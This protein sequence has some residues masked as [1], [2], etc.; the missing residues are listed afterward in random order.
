MHDNNTYHRSLCALTFF[1]RVEAKASVQLLMALLLH[2]RLAKYGI[3]V[4]DV[5]RLFLLLPLLRHVDS[6]AIVRS[7]KLRIHDNDR[8]FRENLNGAFIIFANDATAKNITSGNCILVNV[9]VYA[10][11]FLQMLQFLYGLAIAGDRMS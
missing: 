11:F 6:A 7:I 3:L 5:H 10:D 2:D 9:N 8:I 4:D 1:I